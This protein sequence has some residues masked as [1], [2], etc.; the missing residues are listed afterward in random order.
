MKMIVRSQM[1]L[2]RF[3]LLNNYNVLQ[4]KNHNQM[5]KKKRFEDIFPKHFNS[6]VEEQQSDKKGAGQIKN[7][8]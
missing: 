5:E 4:R 6:V 1:K 8:H 3:T 2:R 7:T